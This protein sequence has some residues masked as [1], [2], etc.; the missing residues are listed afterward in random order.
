MLK[1]KGLDARR[2]TQMIAGQVGESACASFVGF[3]KIIADVPEFLDL[4]KLV[5]NPEKAS[6][7]DRPDVMYALCSALSFK[8][9]NK[10]IGN[11][12]KYVERLKAREMGVV[13]IKDAIRRDKTLRSNA[14]VKNWVRNSGR[15]LVL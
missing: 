4:D 5:N 11:I 1:M 7:P 13:L 10:N 12:I 14:D 6:L 15:E 2:L 9:N 3:L 8:A